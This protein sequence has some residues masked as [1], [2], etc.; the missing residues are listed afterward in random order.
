MACT[1]D[2]PS[3]SMSMSMSMSFGKVSSSTGWNAIC[4]SLTSCFCA[5][6]SFWIVAWWIC[7]SEGR[8]SRTRLRVRTLSHGAYSVAL[9][10]WDSSSGRWYGSVHMLDGDEEVEADVSEGGEEGWWK[11]WEEISSMSEAFRFSPILM[12]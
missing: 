7:S 12:L 5:L 4:V 10:H 6:N 2:S 3:S 9:G 11:E 8:L 1:A